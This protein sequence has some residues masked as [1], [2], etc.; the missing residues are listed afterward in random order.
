MAGE[1]DCDL[2]CIAR[3]GII[4]H[5]QNTVLAGRSTS[6]AR[7]TYSPRGGRWCSTCWLVTT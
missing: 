7:S 4:K 2:Q 1:L 6:G 3:A 5:F